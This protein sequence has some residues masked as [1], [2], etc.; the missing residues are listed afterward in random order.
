MNKAFNE[1]P[2]CGHPGTSKYACVTNPFVLAL[3]A[4]VSVIID[5]RYGAI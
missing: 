2:V 1:Q 3:R 5:L 4:S